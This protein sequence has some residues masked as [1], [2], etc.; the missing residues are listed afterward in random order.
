MLRSLQH[1]RFWI[2]FCIYFL[3]GSIFDIVG[4]EWLWDWI[5]LKQFFSYTVPN[6][7]PKRKYWQKR[8]HN[9]I[10][11]IEF[12]PSQTQNISISEIDRQGMVVKLRYAMLWNTAWEPEKCWMT[13]LTYNASNCTCDSLIKW[14]GS[15]YTA[16]LLCHIFLC[17]K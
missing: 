9:F 14:N 12:K 17:L 5:N 8:L 11:T 13:T 6:F 10:L 16:Q 15:V 3:S 7:A 2:V 1:I 4:K